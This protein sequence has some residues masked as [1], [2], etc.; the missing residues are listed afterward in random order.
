MVLLLDTHVV[1]TAGPQPC[2]R[3]QHGEAE[4]SVGFGRGEYRSSAIFLNNCKCPVD[5]CSNSQVLQVPAGNIY[6][7]K[8]YISNLVLN[9]ES[10]LWKYVKEWKTAFQRR[11][12]VLFTGMLEGSSFS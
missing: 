1:L 3:N 4:G 9:S 2:L 8:C 6:N 11:Q 12:Q 7:C 10:A 5:H